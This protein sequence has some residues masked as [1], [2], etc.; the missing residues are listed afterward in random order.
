GTAVA[1]A[2][3]PGAGGGA[4]CGRLPQRRAV[5]GVGH[6]RA[7]ATACDRVRCAPLARRHGCEE[8]QRGSAMAGTAGRP[9]ALRRGR[10]PGVDLGVAARGPV[11]AGGA[12]LRVVPGAAA[13]GVRRI[14]GVRARGACAP[15]EVTEV[16]LIVKV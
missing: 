14:A 1:G 11:E 9:R 3:A 2:G 16:R 10:A 8:P 7:R 6:V 15:A 13:A 12:P 4:L 5:C